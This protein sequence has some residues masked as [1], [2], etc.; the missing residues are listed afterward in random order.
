[1]VSDQRESFQRLGTS[2][3]CIGLEEVCALGEKLPEEIRGSGPG[4]RE[5]EVGIDLDDKP[6]SLLDSLNAWREK[7]AIG[8][9]PGIPGLSRP[10]ELK[11]LDFLT[12]PKYS[13]DI[14]FF[15]RGE[16]QDPPEGSA[17]HAA[18]V[19]ASHN[20]L[21]RDATPL[22]SGLLP[23]ALDTKRVADIS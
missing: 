10:V 8:D 18:R 11:L 17:T 20:P 4:K 14:G 3:A 5:A 16:G 23:T 12:S 15:L 21:S 6:G 7:V 1:M 22:T 2:P 9:L 13:L 19:E